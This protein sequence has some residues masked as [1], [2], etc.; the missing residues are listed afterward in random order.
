MVYT[1]EQLGIGDSNTYEKT[2]TEADVLL[3][4]AVSGDANPMHVNDE[5]ARKSKFGRRIAH[6]ALTASLFSTAMTRA[7]PTSIYI[8]QYT[9]FCAPVYIGDTIQ[10]V[11]TCE[12]K[13]GKGR[14]RMKTEGFNQQGEKV[15]TGEAV[16]RLARE[17]PPELL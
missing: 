5:F 16:T 9:E 11:V 3:F 1:Y 15:V 7:F 6:G 4:S 12:E 8:S 13:L 14:V 17:I 10:V 2:I